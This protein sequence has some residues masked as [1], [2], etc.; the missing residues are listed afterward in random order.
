MSTTLPVPYAH[1]IEG[2]NKGIDQTGPYYRVVLKI[3]DWQDSDRFINA[4]MGYT[5]ASGPSGGITV[6]R[7]TPHQHPLSANL[8]AHS[9][10]VVQG[11]GNPILSPTGYPNYDG[12][13]LI[14][15]E[16]RPGNVDYG[17]I[18]YNIL[19]NQIDPNTPTTWCTQ[20]I[21]FSTVTFTLPKCKYTY[22]TGP[23]GK[24][25]DMPVSFM[26]PITTLVLT[27]HKLPY[28]P[29]T[30]V[31]ARRGRINLTTFLGCAPG[32][33]L[34]KGCKTTREWNQDGTVVQKVQMTFE[35]RDAAHPWN[36]LPSASDPTFYPV[37]SATAAKMYRLVD[38]NPLVQLQ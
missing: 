13:A 19:N 20:E 29:M 28:L 5:T 16:Y 4:I 38:L 15:V 34:F 25:P 32:L 6:T 17:P 10:V 9:A 27:F 12:G 8:Y 18:N 21:D 35:E 2:F 24:S 1:T 14:E 30:E 11:L 31:R 3:D 26:I 33:V 7:Q 36:S 37:S 22:D 23:V